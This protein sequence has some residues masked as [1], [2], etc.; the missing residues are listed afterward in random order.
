MSDFEQLLDDVLTAH[1]L[2]EAEAEC[3]TA[4][5][6]WEEYES[7]YIANRQA[8]ADHV[9]AQAARIREFEAYADRLAE[10]LPEGMLPK[11]VESLRDANAQMATR[12][13]ELEAA[14]AELAADAEAEINQRY[15]P[16]MQGIHPAMR[17]RYERDMEPVR[18]AQALLSETAQGDVNRIQKLDKAARLALSLL[19]ALR[20]DNGV[21]DALPPACRETYAAVEAQLRE[22]IE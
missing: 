3:C 2:M 6:L 8:A 9:E 12:I 16:R 21:G 5:G 1:R 15:D 20:V 7:D 14:L 17:M 13:Q 4:P 10:G 11:D 22:A 19:E 18:K